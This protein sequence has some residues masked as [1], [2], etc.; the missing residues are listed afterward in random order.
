MH[1]LLLNSLK[2]IVFNLLEHAVESVFDTVLSASGQEFNNLGP[3]IT[4][5]FPQL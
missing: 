4:Y 3:S 5:L 2:L 1:T